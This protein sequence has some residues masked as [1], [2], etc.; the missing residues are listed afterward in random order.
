MLHGVFSLLFGFL[1][2]ALPGIAA[3]T[4]ILLFGFFALAD[5]IFAVV[6]AVW[7]VEHGERWGALVIE[8]LTSIIAGVIAIIAP[9]AAAVGFVLVIGLWAI[10]TGI[11]EAAGAVR[12]R[13]EVQGEM[14]LG[15]SGILSVL[16]GI[17]VLANP[18]AGQLAL[19]WLVGAYAPI[20]GIILVALAFRLRGLAPR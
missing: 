17:F 8:G 16:F 10:V 5:G 14:L 20:F 12:L 2:L 11:L 18:G 3:E 7:A 4:L 1:A 15:I 13:R 9:L 6:T 19:V